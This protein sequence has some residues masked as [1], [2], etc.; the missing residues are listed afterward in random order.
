MGIET[1]YADG[2][3]AGIQRQLANPTPEEGA[4]FSTRSFLAAGM[5]GVPAAGLQVGGSVMDL[6]K[7]SQIE[8]LR[9]PRPAALANQPDDSAR[10]SADLQVFGTGG[11]P[12]RTK[13]EEFAPD[14]T[15]AHTADQVLYGFTRVGAKVAAATLAAPTLPIAGVL[16]AAEGTN[17]AYHELRAKGI[18]HET[19]LKVAGIEGAG[20][21]AAVL[22]MAG[23]TI[24]KTVALTAAAGPGTFM[25]Q[26]KLSREILARA[27]YNDEAS[28]HDPLDPLGL[29]I[30]TLIPA[31]F[32]G[33]HAVGLAR[34]AKPAPTLASVVEGIE[35][36]GKRYGAD[37]KLLT[38]PKGAQ[39]EMQV[40][41]KTATDP[42]FGVVPAKDASTEELARVGRDYLEAMQHRYGSPDLA[43]AAYNAGPGAVDAALNKAAKD[44][45]SWISH[46]PD[47]TQAYVAKGMKKLGADTAAHAATDSVAVDAARTRVTQ[48]ALHRTLPN[49]P[50][51]VGEVMKASDALAAGETPR[52]RP[53]SFDSFRPEDVLPPSLIERANRIIEASPKEERPALLT[54]EQAAKAR[55]ELEPAVRAA[56]EAKPA[57]DQQLQQLGRDLGAG[58]MVADVKGGARLLEKHVLENG[59]DVASMRD[60]VRGSLVVDKVKDVAPALA[61]LQKRFE[62]TRIKDRFSKPL[63]SGYRDVLV[64]VRLPHG[65][66]GEIQIHIPEMISAKK[67][68]HKVYDIERGLAEDHPDKAGHVAVQNEIYAAAFAGN[69]GR[70]SNLLNPSRIQSA[71]SAFESSSPSLRTLD[72][73]GNGRDSPAALT[74]TQ[75]LSGSRTTAMPSTSKNFEP[76][77]NEGTFIS[78]SEPIVRAP[79]GKPE[80]PPFRGSQVE[81]LV[82]DRPDM[83]VQMPGSDKTV[84]AAEALKL[85]KEEHAA[86]LSQ[87]DLVKAALECALGFGG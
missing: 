55:V 78:T 12:L 72:A 65:G 34:A 56:Q 14:P 44:G 86:E 61:E 39:G 26:E 27:G 35:S 74:A 1:L 41:P 15:T 16:L 38:S 84:T 18:D 7:G 79:Q 19:A 70:T 36:S 64:N 46:L 28:R 17:T 85:A 57:F 13:A 62:V 20:Q 4:S 47:E 9:H 24:A 23:P 25:A 8:S 67:L 59:S 54:D 32:G 3:E 71:N 68:G 45:S 66:E 82:T 11:E 6:L 30:A 50:E 33:A 21:A 43:M 2:I 42:G 77:G 29:T 75:E 31:A 22:P 10:R 49:A 63:S 51:A 81:Q 60:L 52:V 53:L 73:F 69:E 87:G 58:V 83:P 37:G 80:A 48:D 5:K 40:M 76:S